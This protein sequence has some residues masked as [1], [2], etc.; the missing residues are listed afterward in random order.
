MRFSRKNRSDLIAL[1]T[2]VHE[3]KTE[4]GESTIKTGFFPNNVLLFTQQEFN[5]NKTLTSLIFKKSTKTTNSYE[6][7]VREVLESGKI[8]LNIVSN[9][10][11]IFDS[12]CLPISQLFFI[13][14]ISD[15]YQIPIR[16]ICNE[17]HILFNTFNEEISISRPLNKI[18]SLPTRRR[19]TENIYILQRAT[20]HKNRYNSPG[21]IIIGTS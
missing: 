12:D 17:A 21:N 19:N 9:Y 5:N 10:S 11:Y 18:D 3:S 7:M 1:Y 15:K 4:K 2:S 14:R 16:I 6:K 8:D 20:Y 13:W